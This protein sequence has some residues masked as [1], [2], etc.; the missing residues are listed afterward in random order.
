MWTSPGPCFPAGAFAQDTEKAK[1]DLE[2]G[3][4]PAPST[5]YEVPF[6]SGAMS[7]SITQSKGKFP[8]DRFGQKEANEQGVGLSPRA[9][10]GFDLGAAISCHS[11]RSPGF[12]S[13]EAAVPFAVRKVYT[14]KYGRQ[15]GRKSKL[16]DLA[17]THSAEAGTERE[18]T[19]VLTNDAHVQ[20]HV[21]THSQTRPGEQ[22]FHRHAWAHGSLW[23]LA[24]TLHCIH[25]HDFRVTF[26][27]SLS[28]AGYLGKNL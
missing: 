15:I 27:S 11:C 25:I 26:C 18:H 1:W 16:R 6:S 19:G 8:G 12:S 14:S 17:W 9:G 3:L 21:H 7:G 22:H 24:H 23:T 20:M 13:W 2:H 5:L 10:S 4:T 28:K